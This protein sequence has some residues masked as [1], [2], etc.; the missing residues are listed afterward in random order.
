MRIN[1]NLIPTVVTDINGR[2]T[3]VHKKP[4]TAA[5]VASVPAPS[6][7]SFGRKEMVEHNC[8]LIEGLRPVTGY[9][10]ARIRQETWSTVNGYSDSFLRVLEKAL[11][12]DSRVASDVADQVRRGEFDEIIREGLHFFKRMGM[13]NYPRC[14]ALVRSLNQ[15]DALSQY[16]STDLA[17]EHVQQQCI[18]IMNAA[19][20][21]TE[22]TPFGTDKEHH[23]LQFI[24]IEGD[25]T[26]PVI[27][28][29]LLVEF[30]MER[31]DDAKEIARIAAKHMNSEPS[32]IIGIMHGINPAIAEGG[33]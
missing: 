2:T 15:Y 25:W 26:M 29:E 20:V 8:A 24:E 6:L 12:G 4:N 33:L 31:P 14:A 17:E 1:P 27:K 10:A 22:E 28:D 21:L 11:K 5:S 13:T 32:F 16:P 18:A 3:T 23:L 30:I 7:R 9:E 19:M